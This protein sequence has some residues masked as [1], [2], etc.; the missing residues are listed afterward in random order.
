[1]AQVLFLRIAPLA[2]FLE[3]AVA[4]LL[5]A[6]AL[7]ALLT[8]LSAFLRTRRKVLFVV[9]S[10]IIQGRFVDLHLRTFA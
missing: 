6:A 3:I 1:M 5:V 10:E 4:V 7:H 9:A 2:V 8:L